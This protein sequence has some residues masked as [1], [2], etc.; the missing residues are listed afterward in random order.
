MTRRVP[1]RSRR[2]WA[3]CALFLLFLFPLVP[4]RLA[5]A[6]LFPGYPEAVRMQAV[7]VV[8]AAGPGKG[9]ALEREVRAL[10]RAMFDHAILSMNA[11]PDRIF[12]R[13]AREGWK[14]RS[15]ESLRAVARVAPLSVPLW[16]WLAREDAVAV[17]AR[18]V[19]LRRRRIVGSA[20]PVRSR[21]ARARRVARSVRLR[22][23]VLVRRLG[24]AQS[25]PAGAPRT[26]VG[27]CPPLQGSPPAGDLRLRDRPRRFCGPGRVWGRDRR[28]RGLLDRTLDRVPAPRRAR[29][30]GNGDP[31]AGRRLPLR[32]LPR[33]DSPDGGN[34]RGRGD[35]WEGRGTTPGACRIPEM[36]GGAC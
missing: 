7:R 11:V 6:D 14:R 17:S 9:E 10:R 18:G 3:R 5:A 33:S 12:D 1:N 29:D 26:D 22:L 2:S 23:G 35:G 32:R 16:A 21:A 20:S 13:A 15:Y 25:S 34:R 27:R 28:R 4:S 24:V 36:P 30:R 8:E 19:P 31:A